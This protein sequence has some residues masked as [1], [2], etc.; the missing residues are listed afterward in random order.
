MPYENHRGDVSVSRSARC[1]P[2]SGATAGPPARRWRF[3]TSRERAAAIRAAEAARDRQL[4]ADA[5]DDVALLRRRGFVVT[6]EGH[7]CRV[8]NTLCSLADLRAKAARERRLAEAANGMTAVRP[9]ARASRGW[10][11]AARKG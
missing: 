2:W 7:R 4:Y 6:R 8:G 1:T 3:E 5:V 11:V 9:P 10:I